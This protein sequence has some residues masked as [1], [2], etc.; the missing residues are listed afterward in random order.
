M[1]HLRVGEGIHEHDLS[2]L[3]RHKPRG[4]RQNVPKGRRVLL[5]YDRAGID[6]AFWKRCRQECAIYFLSRTKEGMKFDWI[7]DLEWDPQD[8]RNSG[9]SE[10]RQVV[11]PEGHTLR[12]VRYTEPLTGKFYEFLTNEMDLPPGV[13]AELYRRRWEIEK[14]FDE[15]K[16][17]LEE[18]KAWG[19]GLEIRAVQGQ[20]CALTHN[21][22]VLYESHLEQTHGIRNVAEDRRRDQRLEQL[23]SVA[24]TTGRGISTLLLV[25][26]KATQ[27]SIKF[28]RWLR[29]ALV[30]N[31]TESTAVPRLHVLYA[32]L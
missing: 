10:D 1:R 11:S 32:H 14:S 19:T 30:E 5:V 9:V 29:H 4:L 21:L 24:D 15:L 3:K 7:R 17:Q 2:M 28:L 13:L 26:R 6:Y 12:V 31:L 23:K 27:R 18:T 8:P 16:N 20:F 22:L 25:A